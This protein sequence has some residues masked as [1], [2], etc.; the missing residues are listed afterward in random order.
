MTNTSHALIDRI[1]DV[2]LAHLSSLASVLP[3]AGLTGCSPVRTQSGIVNTLPL[4]AIRL[5]AG[6][7]AKIGGTLASV[8]FGAAPGVPPRG[9]P[10]GRSTWKRGEG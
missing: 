7:A 2:E 4:K 6:G 10:S 1:V 9:A 3:V 5:L 8:I